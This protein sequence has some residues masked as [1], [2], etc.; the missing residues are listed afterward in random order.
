M[1][2]EK[3]KEQEGLNFDAE[4]CSV[5]DGPEAGHRLLYFL[6]GLGLLCGGLFLVLQNTVLTTK[7]SLIDLLGFNPPFGLVILPVLIGIGV[8]FFNSRS[9]MGWVMTALG[10]LI[11]LLGILMGLTIFFR[12]VTLF[13]GILMFGLI[14]AGLGM[15]AKALVPKGSKSN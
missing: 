5:N 9:L 13:Q 1:E 10:T 6:V 3:V 15:L 12:P 4:K 8:L 2:R 7:F 14:A 11:I